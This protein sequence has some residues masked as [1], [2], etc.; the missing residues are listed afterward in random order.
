MYLVVEPLSNIYIFTE[1]DPRNDGYHGPLESNVKLEDVGTLDDESVN[2]TTAVPCVGQSPQ[3]PKH[4]RV[5]QSKKDCRLAGFESVAT[6]YCKYQSW[7][8]FEDD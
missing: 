5:F 7:G 4:F 3:N 2:S 6:V 1:E 8:E